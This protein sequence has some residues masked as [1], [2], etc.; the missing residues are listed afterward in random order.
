MR[1]G[2]I[3][4]V[5]SGLVLSRKQSRVPTIYRYPLLNLRSVNPGGYVDLTA[6]DIFDATEPLCAEYLSCENDVIIR[7]SAPYTAVLIDASTAGMVISSN[8]VIIRPDSP[9]ILPDYL[10]W[11]LNTLKV[12]RRIYENTGSNMLGAIKP[13]YFIDFDVTLLSIADQQRIASM[14]L[15]AK[16]ERQLLNELAEEKEKYYA[17]TIEKI[18][19]QMRRGTRYDD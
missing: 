11:L 9:K 4:V 17:L 7:L 18:Q 12:K 15:L 16:R 19:K 10:Y 5:R 8:F 1:L 6:T 3:A 14:N 13:R 2:D